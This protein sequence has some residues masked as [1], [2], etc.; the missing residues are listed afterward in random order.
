MN[1]G[2]YVYI[3]KGN[4]LCF[5]YGKDISKN[6]YKRMMYYLYIFANSD[7]LFCFYVD[8]GIHQEPQLVSCEIF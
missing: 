1:V 8:A 2:L 4:S 6:L 3:H 5:L 7:F